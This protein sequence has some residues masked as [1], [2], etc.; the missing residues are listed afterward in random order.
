MVWSKTRIISSLYNNLLHYRVSEVRHEPN[1]SVLSLPCFTWGTLNKGQTDKQESWLIGTN[2]PWTAHLTLCFSKL[3]S[4][5]AVKPRF[6]QGFTLHKFLT[7]HVVPLPLHNE[8]SSCAAATL[9]L[10]GKKE[11]VLW[12]QPTAGLAFA[13]PWEVSGFLHLIYLWQYNNGI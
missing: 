1:V 10:P 5:P 13:L 4:K 11:P 6:K 7:A 9:A 12:N 2:W 8:V 3:F